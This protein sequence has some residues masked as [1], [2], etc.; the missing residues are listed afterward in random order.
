MAFDTNKKL[1]LS[2]S[3]LSITFLGE[4]IGG[5]VFGSLSLVSDSFH[6]FSDIFALVIAHDAAQNDEFYEVEGLLKVGDEEIDL[7]DYYQIAGWCSW[8]IVL[9]WINKLLQND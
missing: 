2:V 7:K 9:Q 8:G 4:L 5:L 6:V 3:I 1:L